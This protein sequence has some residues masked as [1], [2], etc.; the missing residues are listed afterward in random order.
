MGGGSGLKGHWV[1][2]R[3][4]MAWMGLETSVWGSK[5]KKKLSW[6]HYIVCV[7]S[8]LNLSNVVIGEKRTEIN[9]KR[10]AK[11]LFFVLPPLLLVWFTLLRLEPV[12]CYPCACV[13]G[14]G[15]GWCVVMMSEREL[16]ERVNM[17][18]LLISHMKWSLD[19]ADM[20][21]IHCT[22][23]IRAVFNDL[24]LSSARC[25]DAKFSC[26]VWII[27]ERLPCKKPYLV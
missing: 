10:V 19:Y 2:M 27:S 12:V 3:D 11:L 26:V 8:G 22:C 24:L 20:S 6:T 13:R 9:K 16:K 5:A 17:T 23:C 14:V 21:Y 7:F 18:K 15:G 4:R 25:I 1:Q